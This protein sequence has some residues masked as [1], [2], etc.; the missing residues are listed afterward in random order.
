V[1]GPDFLGIGVSRAGTTYLYQY[2]REHP[3]VWLPPIKE[4]HFFDKHK[5][6]WPEG[7]GRSLANRLRFFAA[8]VR[9]SGGSWKAQA[10]RWFALSYLRGDLDS[11]STYRRHFGK[12]R[13]GIVRGEITPDYYE[14]DGERVSGIRRDFPHLKIILTIRHPIERFESQVLKYLSQSRDADPMASVSRWLERPGFVRSFDYVSII[15][16]WRNVFGGNDFHVSYFDQLETDPKAYLTDICRFI[17]VDAWIPAHMDLE[18]PVNSSRAPGSSA[19]PEALVRN[20]A[21]AVMPLLCALSQQESDTPA[22]WFR[23]VE[24]VAA[25]Q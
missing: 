3:R 6:G 7:N 25:E 5:Y 10:D 8:T 15:K 2:L 18:R 12:A 9:R 14:L 1:T 24:Q 17:G 20:F 21:R 22:R 13:E 19:L 16:R 4:L 23:D 11:P